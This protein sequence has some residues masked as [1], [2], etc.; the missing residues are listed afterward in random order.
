M[1]YWYVIVLSGLSGTLMA[2]TDLTVE[3]TTKRYA[4]GGVLRVALCPNAASFDTEVGCTLRVADVNSATVRVVFRDVS[5]GTYAIKVFHDVNAD[6]RMDTNF[7]GFPKESYGFSN[8]AMG[9]FGP[10]AFEQAA[11]TVGDR[12]SQR[13]SIQ[14]R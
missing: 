4:E 13:H 5:K 1:R 8:D 10:P 7:I 9:R 6:G 12:P 11:F 14:L 2:Q 3:V